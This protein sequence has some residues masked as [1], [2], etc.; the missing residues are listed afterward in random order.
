MPRSTEVR[1]QQ[2]CQEALAAK[3]SAELERVIPELR[4]ALEEHTRLAKESLSD[5]R[6]RIAARDS[7]SETKTRKDP[8]TK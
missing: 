1:I 8:S 5:Q 2:L 4:A 7:A 6:N 3:T